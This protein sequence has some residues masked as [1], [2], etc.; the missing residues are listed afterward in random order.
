MTNT[1]PKTIEEY[2]AGLSDDKRSALEQLRK[3]IHAAAP[4]AEE[5][6]SY[7]LPAFRLNGKVF[8]WFGAGANH[9]AIYG[10]VPESLK[11]ELKTYDTSGKGTLRFQPANPLPAAFVKKLVKARI[12]KV[13]AQL[14]SKEKS[15]VRKA[16]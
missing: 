5:C 14:R 11:D 7:K 8:I 2:L 10:A 9:C 6:I 13:A 4:K 12:T 15:P 3:I 1:N 16:R